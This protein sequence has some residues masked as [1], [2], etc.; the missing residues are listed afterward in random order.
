MKTLNKKI[1]SSFFINQE[2]GWADL[3]AR[4]KEVGARSGCGSANALYAILRG[5]DYRK[6]L[7]PITN[8]NKLN[9]G[10][11]HQ[12]EGYR[13]LRGRQLEASLH[14]FDGIVYPE[15]LIKIQALL[16]PMPTPYSPDP[17]ELGEYVTPVTIEADLVGA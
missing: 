1:T 17:F 6:G 8:K 11:A 15:V 3:K 9:N 16:P 13:A 10:G 5:K 7:T 2:T 12:W 4:W 14:M